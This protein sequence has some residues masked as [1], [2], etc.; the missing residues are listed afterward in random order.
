MSGSARPAETSSDSEHA[1]DRPV[2]VVVTGDN[3]LSPALPRMSPQR[4][5][6]RR[7]WLRRAFLAAVD[8]A[9]S[10]EA[11]L[12]VNTGDLFDSPAPSNQD[13]AFVAE[14]LHRLRAANVTCVAISGNH[15][16]P[17]MQTEHGGDAPQQVYSAND[18]LHYFASTDTLEPRLFSLGGLSVA[19]VGLSVNPVASPGSDPLAVARWS[20]DAEAALAQADVALLTLH[21]AIEGM[22]RPDEGERTVMQASVA[23]LP[24]AVRVVVAGHIHRFARQRVGEREVVVVGATE[25]MEFGAPS[26]APGFVWIELTREGA[27][28]IEH[29]RTQAQPRADIT[30]HTSTLW[31]DDADSRE[32]DPATASVPDTPNHALEVIRARLEAACTPETLVRMRLTGEL[33]RAR[34]QQLALRDVIALGQRIAFTLDVDTSGLRLLEPAF[35][36]PSLGA[37]AE[38]LSPAQM[39]ALVVE[40]TLRQREAGEPSAAELPDPDDLRAASALLLARLRSSGEE[41]A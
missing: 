16:T 40:E 25:R 18:D 36:L 24:A 4:R 27:R 22:A 9:I 31:P 29:V 5:Q 15:D 23:A 38:A 41:G 21:A 30:L 39:I 34:Y 14:Q 20:A 35:A 11:A 12:F 2:G 10:R 28:R 33:S 19:V 7:A 3:H 8:Y 1:Q 6:E 13:R 17:R 26:V 32:D 37:R